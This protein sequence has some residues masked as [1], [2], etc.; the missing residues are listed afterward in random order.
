MSILSRTL[1]KL[2]GALRRHAWW[3]L[4]WSQR[5]TLTLWGRSLRA[6]LTGRGSTDVG[7]VRRLVTA[8]YKVSSDWRLTNSA[9]L[10][11]LTLV[12]DEV[13]AHTDPH[14]PQ[15]EVLVSVLGGVEQLNGVRFTSG[16]AR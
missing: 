15:R 5:H 6:E 3:L 8:L 11:L 2:I 13:V 7:R 9:G 1:V 14:W 12:D 4:A 10:T 16:R